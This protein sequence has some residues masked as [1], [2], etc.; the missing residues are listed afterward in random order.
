MA[1]S[2]LAVAMIKAMT[3]GHFYVKKVYMCAKIAPACPFVSPSF[4]FEVVP[5][6][7][8]A[9]DRFTAS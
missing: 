4:R 7:R 2:V 6:E 1:F 8:Y 3:C 5:D 9:F